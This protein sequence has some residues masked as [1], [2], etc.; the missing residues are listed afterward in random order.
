VALALLA[1]LYLL[2]PGSVQGLTGF[3]ALYL[4]LISVLTLPHVVIVG[5]MDLRQGLWR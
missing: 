5:L 2:T 4:V 3:L 1:G